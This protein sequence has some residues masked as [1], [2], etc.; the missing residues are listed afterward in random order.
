M[1]YA[2]EKRKAKGVDMIAA[3]LVAAA[4]GGFERDENSLIVLWEEGE[5]PADDR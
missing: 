1:E 2:Q 5:R 4:E 3:N